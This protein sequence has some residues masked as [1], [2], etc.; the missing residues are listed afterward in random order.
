[1]PYSLVSAATLG[2]DLVRL[3]AGRSVA[4]GPAGRPRCRRR[5]PRRRRRRPP[6][7]RPGPRASAACSPSAPARPASWPPP[8]RT[9]AAPPTEPRGRPRRRPRRPARARHHR[10]RP[11]ARA[12]APGRRPRA[13]APGARLPAPTT[14]GP[15]PPTCS[16]TPRSGYWAAGVL[17]PLVRRELTGPFDRVL[18]RG[19][20][21]A[22]AGATS[23]AGCAEL[24]DAVRDLDDA[25]RAAWRAAVDE[26][27]ADHRP[28]ATAMHEASW[29]AHVSGRTRDA[30][31]RPAARRPGV[32]RR[33]L[34]PP[35][36]RRRRLERARRLRAGHGHGRPARRGLARRPPG[37]LARGVTGGR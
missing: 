35:R 29:A 12:A 7:P 34:R 10:R 9:C 36:R 32:P 31:R 4:D 23:A 18:D 26:G 3:P 11:D 33:R 20:V 17:P 30:R 8:S 21:S 28:W 25:G 13:R 22:A 37:A 6:R 27:R 1:M 16:P 24:L 5:P 14:S 19:A 15:R 2:F